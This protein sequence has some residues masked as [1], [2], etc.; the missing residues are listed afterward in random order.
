MKHGKWL[1][2]LAAGTLV[3]A[4]LLGVALAAGQQ[5]TQN[6]PLVSLSYLNQKATPSIL[7]QVNAKVTEQSQTLTN[8]F[9]DLIKSYTGQMED[10]LNAAAGGDA[11]S[12]AF[13]VV[14]VAAGQKLTA[15][16]GC[17]IMLRVGSAVCFT[18]TPPGFIDMTGGGTLENGQALVKNHLYMAT[19]AGRGFTA[20][21]AVK[22]MV[23]GE[24]TV[25]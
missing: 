8:Q 11:Q 19:I 10:K 2:R 23:R 15:G 20:Q 3:T 16:I 5:G 12:A 13:S 1:P 6:D 24:Y 7:E 25:S 17:E 22:V 4:A 9:N 21:D 14:D 18:D